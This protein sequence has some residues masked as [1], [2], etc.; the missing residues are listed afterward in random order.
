MVRQ[1]GLE[2]DVGG[3]E[4]GLDGIISGTGNIV[5]EHGLLHR[6]RDLH[7]L[8]ALA[9]PKPHLRIGPE[10]TWQL[11]RAHRRYI[12]I[13]PYSQILIPIAKRRRPPRLGGRYL[14][15][16]VAS[17]LSLIKVQKPIGR[18]ESVAFGEG[19]FLF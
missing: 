17:L 4:C 7:I 6:P 8:P 2:G 10:L 18:A 15:K 11:I 9:K 5:L 19:E 3:L 1:A 13:I 12:P 16:R 14:I